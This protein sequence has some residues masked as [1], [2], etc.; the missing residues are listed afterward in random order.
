[1]AVFFYVHPAWGA[2]RSHSTKGSE[3][4]LERAKQL[5]GF[6]EVKEIKEYVESRQLYIENCFHEDKVKFEDME[7]CERKKE[8]LVYCQKPYFL[9]AYS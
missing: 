6:E 5:V 3:R 1:M 8:L 7:I 9:C 2:S 4:H